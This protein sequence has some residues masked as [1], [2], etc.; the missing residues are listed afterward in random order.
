ML[1]HNGCLWQHVAVPERCHACPLSR[2]V[3][4]C[5]SVILSNVITLSLAELSQWHGEENLSTSR[6][7][8]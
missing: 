3:S 6:G 8:V 5:E 4:A 1:S 2:I 7:E